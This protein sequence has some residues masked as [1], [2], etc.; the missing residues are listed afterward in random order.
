MRRGSFPAYE[1][2]RET[3]SPTLAGLCCSS[4]QRL[5]LGALLL[6]V[7]PMVGVVGQGQGSDCAINHQGEDIRSLANPTHC[8]ITER[9]P[10]RLKEENI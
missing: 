5:S 2:K 8:N 9:R 3:P 10:I 7:P 6:L 1:N 4:S